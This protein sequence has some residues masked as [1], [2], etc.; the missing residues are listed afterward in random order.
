LNSSRSQKLQLE[1]TLNHL[2]VDWGVC[3]VKFEEQ[4]NILGKKIEA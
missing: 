2:G 4:P 1:N 3:D